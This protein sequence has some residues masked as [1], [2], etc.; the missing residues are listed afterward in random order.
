MTPARRNVQLDEDSLSLARSSLPASLQRHATDGAKDATED[1]PRGLAHLAASQ[2]DRHLA[3]LGR[4]EDD[5]QESSEERSNHR[6]SN[7]SHG[8]KMAR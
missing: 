3:A 8:R 5:D 2:V 4:D 7:P 6:C 1:D